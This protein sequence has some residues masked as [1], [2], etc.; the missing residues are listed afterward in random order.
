MT[1]VREKPEEQ[2]AG[3]E[4]GEIH[5]AEACDGKR[6]DRSTSAQDEE[7]VE[8]VAAHDIA[9]GQSALSLASGNDACGQFGQTGAT[10]HECQADDGLAH[11]CRPGNAA[12]TFDKQFAPTYQ[13]S[14]AQHD[15][16]CY[17]SQRHSGGWAIALFLFGQTVGI[18]Q[19]Y[20]KEAEQDDAI[21]SR[22]DV[23]LAARHHGV[24]RQG[25]QDDAGQNAQGDVL[26]HG[27]LGDG[28]GRKG[29]GSPGYDQHVEQVAAHDVAGT[30]C[31][32]SAVVGDASQET[33]DEFGQ[34]GAKGH[35]RQ[36]DDHLRYA[37]PRGQ[38]HSSV[39]KFVGTD[40]YERGTDNC[41]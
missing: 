7:D 2:A 29:G 9:D 27:G 31:R 40:Q 32:G 1:A 34:T 4:N 21:A 37:E 41:V 22:Q 14:E 25:R 15:E 12:C 16:Q 6:L 10:G 18:G 24:E 17:P 36:A 23:G 33:H 39:R 8:D 19:E 35:N 3:H 26:L 28:D 5:R 11:S 38:A 20:G 30:E 13:C